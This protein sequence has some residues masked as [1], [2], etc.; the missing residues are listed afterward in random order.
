MG[1]KSPYSIN[2]TKPDLSFTNDFI[3][4]CWLAKS[5]SFDIS[6]IPEGVESEGVRKKEE[7]LLSRHTPA[8]LALRT[9]YAFGAVQTFRDVNRMQ[10]KT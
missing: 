8:A 6:V 4:E 10:M 3:T 2:H 1:D 5:I 9:D 7:K